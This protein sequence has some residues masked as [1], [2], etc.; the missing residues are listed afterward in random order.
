MSTINRAP[1]SIKHA[2]QSLIQEFLKRFAHDQ[3]WTTDPD[4]SHRQLKVDI[5]SRAH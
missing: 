5:P 4:S 1:G 2:N 3:T